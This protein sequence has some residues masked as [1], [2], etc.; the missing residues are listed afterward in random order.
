[1][2]REEIRARIEEVGIFPAVRVGSADLALFAAE[3]VYEAGIPIAEITMTVP[4]AVGVIAQLSRQY[5]ALI[6]GAGTVL[7]AET[8]QRCLDAGARFLTSPGL[9][10]EVVDFA[11]HKNVV[12]IPGAL[13]PSEV[14]AAWKAGVDFVKIFPC[15]PV[16]GDKYLR[17]L[18]VPLPQVRLIASGGVNQ[19]TAAGFI[20][21]GA[22]AIGIGAELMPREALQMR[23]REW[24]QELAR[25][26]T[27]IVRESRAQLAM[28]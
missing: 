19:Q 5:P 7:D 22:S 4:G 10:P 8:A 27:T 26:F 13:T 16:G 12:I 9:V 11:L 28:G 15:A 3:S 18:K 2:K 24:I 6:V 14:I 17:A 1:M 21:A 25:R 20:L 23:K